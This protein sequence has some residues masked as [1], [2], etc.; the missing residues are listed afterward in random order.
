[1]RVYERK[2]MTEIEVPLEICTTPKR[3]DKQFRSGMSIL[4]SIWHLRCTSRF[5]TKLLRNLI[6]TFM[7]YTLERIIMNNKWHL[8]SKIRK[9]IFLVLNLVYTFHAEFIWSGAKV[10][11]QRIKHRKNVMCIR[12]LGRIILEFITIT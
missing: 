2:I 8:G 7:E 3:F 4:W 10:F 5:E 12:S 6:Y 1:M 11:H 9:I